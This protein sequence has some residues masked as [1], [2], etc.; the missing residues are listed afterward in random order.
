[1]KEEFDFVNFWAREY[2]KNYHKNR[3][4]LI[5]FVN[6]QIK[7]SQDFLKKL[8]PNKIIQI[9]NI[10]NKNLIEKLKKRDKL[11]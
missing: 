8:E 3:S 4:L 5:K 6:Y 10:K 2:K 9:F 11:S 1:M 7:T